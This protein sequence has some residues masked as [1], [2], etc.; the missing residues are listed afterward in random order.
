[1]RIVFLSVSSS[2]KD[3]TKYRSIVLILCGKLVKK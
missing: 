3:E 2:L 1:M